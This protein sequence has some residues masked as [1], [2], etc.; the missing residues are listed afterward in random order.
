MHTIT[1]V[2]KFPIGD[3][4]HNPDAMGRN[5]KWA[6]ELGAFNINFAPQIAIKSQ[7]LTDFNAEWQRSKC[8]GAL[9]ARSIGPC[10]STAH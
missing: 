9:N 1:V 6:V 2:T 10:T 8:P 7:S 3:I 4:L 5:S